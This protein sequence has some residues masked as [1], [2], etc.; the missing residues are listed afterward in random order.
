MHN[1]DFRPK[2][3]HTICEEIKFVIFLV[4]MHTTTWISGKVQSGDS[5]TFYGL[6]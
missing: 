5:W 3:F 1:C 4:W 2:D 6:A